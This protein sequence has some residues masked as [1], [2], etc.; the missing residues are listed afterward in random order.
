MHASRSAVVRRLRVAAAVS[1]A[2]A[3][4]GFGFAALAARD[5]DGLLAAGDFLVVKVR[6]VEH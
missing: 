5:A 2:P 4:S 6:S 1:P 3:A